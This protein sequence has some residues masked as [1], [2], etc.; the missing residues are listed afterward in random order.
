[1]DANREAQI[2]R[3]FRAYVQGDSSEPVVISAVKEVPFEDRSVVVGRHRAELEAID[4]ARLLILESMLLPLH[5]R[6]R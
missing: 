5:D 6:S 2:V 3:A 1:M 4:G